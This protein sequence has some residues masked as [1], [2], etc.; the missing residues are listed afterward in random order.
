[1]PAELIVSG[2]TEDEDSFFDQ[3]TNSMADMLDRYLSCQSLERGQIVSGTVVRVSPG[4]IIVDVGAKCEG[5]VSQGDL[6]KM[7]PAE[8][9]AIRAGDEVP[10]YV[11]NPEDDGGNII[12][13]LSRAQIDRD[14]GEAQ[15]LLES[16]ETI[17]KRVAG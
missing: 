9:D 16:Q 11:V 15:H 1:M 12:L 17:E 6:A 10:V 5:I 2:G 8:R 7:S 14:W 4:E 13:S 3:G